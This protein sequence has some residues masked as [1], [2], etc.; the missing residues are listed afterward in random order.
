MRKAY[1][2]RGGLLFLG[3]VTAL[4][5]CQAYVDVAGVTIRS[6]DVVLVLSVLATMGGLLL[7]G[8]LAQIYNRVGVAFALLM[9]STG[10]SV[11]VTLFQ[12]LDIITKKDAVVNGIRSTLS[13]YLFFAAYHSPA[14]A[15]AKLR[16]ILRV[17]VA[18]SLLTTTVALLQIAHWR[19]WLPF[20]L[21][22]IL[23]EYGER[24]SSAEGREIFG[25]FVSNNNAHVW[26]GMLVMQI[27]AVLAF[28]VMHK[29]YLLRIIGVVYALILLYILSRV[30]V[31]NSILGLAIASIGL[32]FVSAWH[33]RL[34]WNRIL[35]PPLIAAAAALF[36]SAFLALAPDTY[37]VERIRQVMPLF[38]GGQVIVSRG[39]NIYGRLE[40]WQ[41]A[42]KLFIQRP[43][44]GNGFYSY[45]EL[46]RAFRQPSIV[47][48]HNSYLH[49]LAEQGLMGVL[50]LGYMGIELTRF[51]HRLWC[52][53]DKGHVFV[54]SRTLLTG[55]LLFLGFTAIFS[56][57][58]WSPN[59]TGYVA[60]LTGAQ[61]S[62]MRQSRGNP[63]PSRRAVP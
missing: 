59:Q 53:R 62:Y 34:P 63:T 17:T 47:H 57:P 13:F 15:E 24:M 21:P 61:A 4:Y 48:A 7:R 32:G 26:S 22:P 56:N 5:F 51:L 28:I 23:T 2:R 18:F 43:F 37:S 29:R 41:I 11:I 8:H 25:L 27:L 58:L 49:T 36:V 31:R 39:S 10:I 35:K 38:Q 52:H 6:E 45:Q 9:F 20:G 30:S 14:P 19:G 46:S 40:Y 50:A 3:A 44:L 33:N 12:D 42:G 54:A 16:T 60:A 1:P 55:A